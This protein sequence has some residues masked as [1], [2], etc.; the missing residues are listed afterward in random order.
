M[1]RSAR[2]LALSAVI[3]TGLGA[4]VAPHAVADSGDSKRVHA[5]TLRSKVAHVVG[6]EGGPVIGSCSLVV[7]STAR[8]VNDWQSI[9]VRVTGGCAISDTP[10]AA[11]YVGS[12]DAPSDFIFFGDFSDSGEVYGSRTST[13]DVFDNTQLGRRTWQDDFAFTGDQT[14]QYTQNNP[15]TTVKVGSWAALSTT[16][17]GSKVTINTRV[18]RYSTAYHKPIAWAGATGTIQFRA[19]G[20]ST[21]KGLKYAT[22]NSAGTYS[23][24]YINSAKGDYRVVYNTTPY[25]WDATSASSTR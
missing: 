25:I 22:A 6:P 14:A 18:S 7:P 3:A 16:R 1:L 13:W 21:W 15:V 2:A 20:T 5:K 11:W 9:P 10:I 23:Y 24:S 4:A 17:S 8:V 19:A 12:Y